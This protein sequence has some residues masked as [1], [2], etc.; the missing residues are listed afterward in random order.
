MQKS[1]VELQKSQ[2]QFVHDTKTMLNNQSA[3]IINLEVQMGQMTTMLSERPQGTLFSTSEVNRKREGQEHCKAVT[4]RSSKT[5][6][7]SMEVKGN[8]KEP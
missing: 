6:K 4:L 8:D 7:N 2:A 5:I 3:Q 1:Q